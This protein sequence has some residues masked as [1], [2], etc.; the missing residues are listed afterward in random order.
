MVLA[1]SV[2]TVFIVSGP[3]RHGYTCILPAMQTSLELTNTQT[4]ELQT[5]NMLGYMITVVF[6]G[7]LAT[8]FGPRVVI[9]VA[10]FISALGLKRKS[11]S[12]GR[13]KVRQVTAD[14]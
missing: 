3:G 5:W 7:L 14:R 12:Q 11:N 1:L 9:S 10:L 2:L 13:V 4:G 8:R 6:A